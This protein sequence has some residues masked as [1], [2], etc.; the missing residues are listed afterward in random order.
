MMT[1]LINTLTA[2]KLIAMIE[3]I[4]TPEIKGKLLNRCVKRIL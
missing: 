1:H 3:M 4:H 2:E